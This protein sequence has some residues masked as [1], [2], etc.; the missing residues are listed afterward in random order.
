VLY[1]SL[2]ASIHKGQWSWLKIRGVQV[3]SIYLSHI[4]YDSASMEMRAKY[5]IILSINHHH[6]KCKYGKNKN[7]LQTLFNIQQL[8]NNIFQLLLL[9]LHKI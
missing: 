2:T 5:I 4:C 6:S 7:K 9:D 3:I 1:K 8:Y